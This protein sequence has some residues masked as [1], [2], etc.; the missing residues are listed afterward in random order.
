MMAIFRFGG[1]DISPT[2]REAVRALTQL[3]KREDLDSVRRAAADVLSEAIRSKFLKQTGAKKSQVK[4]L[5]WRRLIGKR[6]TIANS[7][8]VD[9]H[10]SLW[11]REGKPWAY[12]SQPYVLNTADLREI[13]KRC[14]EN[15]LHAQVRADASWHFPGKTVAVILTRKHTRIIL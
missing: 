3:G 12:V 4:E 13:V 7:D 6:P 14:D 8:P 9:D 11:N 2:Y 1:V 15:K 10:R 5:H